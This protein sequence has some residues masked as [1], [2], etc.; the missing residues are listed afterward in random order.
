MGRFFWKK[1][2][3]NHHFPELNTK[4]SLGKFL[5][6][7][8]KPAVIV[9]LIGAAILGLGSLYLVQTN[10]N[11]TAGYQMKDLEQRIDGLKQYNRKLNLAYIG[12]Q[13]MDNVTAMSADLKL[14]P[15]GN[16]EIISPLDTAVAMK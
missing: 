8:L 11:A 12:L 6:A 14:V 15:V 10:V 3:S 7:Y 4:K 1:E 16:V 13:S 5:L 9:V 2:K